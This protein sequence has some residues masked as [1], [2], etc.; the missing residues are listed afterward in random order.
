MSRSDRHVH[1]GPLMELLE[2][3]V[4]WVY[5]AELGPLV[6]GVAT[7]HSAPVMSSL[8]AVTGSDPVVWPGSDG[9]ERG[10][11]L[12]PLYPGALRTKSRWSEL[13]DLLTLIDVLRVG[14]RREVSLAMGVICERMGA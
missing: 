6:R 14:R 12:E 9:E 5:Y 8:V 3:G 11:A 7:A 4:R 1:V 13:Y 2:H 10:Q